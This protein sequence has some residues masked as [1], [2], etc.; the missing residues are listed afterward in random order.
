MEII[1]DYDDRIHSIQAI[2]NY[3]EQVYQ[4][5]LNATDLLYDEIR[6]SFI[7]L[8]DS[9]PNYNEFL[10]IDLNGSLIITTETLPFKLSF[11]DNLF[12]QKGKTQVSLGD[13]FLQN[14]IL[15]MRNYSPI[16]YND[17]IIAVI[18]IEE[19]TQEL[20]DITNDYSG[21]GITGETILALRTVEGDALFITNTRFYQNASLRVTISSSNENVPIT[22]ALLRNETIMRDAPDYRGEPV[23]AVTKYIDL[24]DWGIVVKQDQAEIFE[25]IENEQRQML[26][27]SSVTMVVMIFIAVYLARYISLPLIKLTEMSDEAAKGNLTIRAEVKFVDEIIILARSF[28]ALANN[29]SQEIDARLIAEGITIKDAI[30]LQ[31]RAESLDKSNKELDKLQNQL[32]QYNAE[33]EIRV[34]ERTSRMK[35][36]L[37]ELNSFAYTVTH[38]LRAPLRALQ[39]FSNILLEDYSEKMDEEGLSYLTRI[40]YASIK[41][42]KMIQDLLIHSRFTREEFDMELFNP[43]TLIQNSL[44]RLDDIIQLEK[45]NIQIEGDYPQIMLNKVIFDQIIQNLIINSIKFK[46]ESRDLEIKIFS[47]IDSSILRIYVED[48]GIGIE[49]EYFGKIFKVFEKL[50]SE[51]EYAGTGIGLAI[52][53]RG[54]EKMKGKITV[55]SEFGKYTQFCLEFK[56]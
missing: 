53:K 21:L 11:G 36:S 10:I 23:I 54:I 31:E 15:Y 5:M 44:S 18:A 30:T 40:S 2:S 41:M 28:N 9:I 20:W 25:V 8:R 37:N 29:L 34:E 35:E 7:K 6:D 46:N 51:G 16:Y 19:H 14:D 32:K 3:E 50:H 13:F 17:S 4:Y 47:R 38:D 49:E 48:N 27:I 22:Q 42:D 24:L 26:I 52:V 1:D 43:K 55:K 12:F 33:L 56:L 45:V 39:G